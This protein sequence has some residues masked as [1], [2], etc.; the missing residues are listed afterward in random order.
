MK[1]LFEVYQQMQEAAEVCPKCKK[2]PCEC[3]SVEEELKGK[4]IK[5]DKNKNGKLDS[6]D[7]KKLRK[8]D[9]VPFAGPYTK[10]K[11]TV[12][13]K[14]GAKHTGM[15]RARD[16]ARKALANTQKKS[17]FEKYSAEKDKLK[18]KHFGMAEEV[19]QIEELS[20]NTLLSYA[21]KVSADSQKNKMDPTKRNPEKANRSVSGVAKAHNKFFAKEEVELTLEDYSLEELEDYMMSEE[22]EQLDELSKSTLGSYVKKAA[23]DATISRK[24]ASDFEHMSARAKKPSMKASASELEKEYKS[25]SWK[26]RDNIGKAVDR[27]TKEEYKEL[28]EMDHGGGKNPYAGHGLSRDDDDGK[29]EYQAKPISRKTVSKLTLDFLNKNFNTKNKKVTKEEVD[30]Q[31]A[32]HREFASQGKMHPDMA[33]NMVVGRESDYYEPKTGDK[34]SGKVIH[35]NGKE[36]HVKQTADSYDPKKVGTLHKF[37]ISSVSHSSMKEEQMKTYSDLISQ[38]DEYNSKEGVYRHKGKYGTSHDDPGVKSSPFWQAADK[39]EDDEKPKKAAAPAEKRGRGRPAGAKS[40]ARQQGSGSG[41]DYS[42]I[43][44][45]SLNLPNSNR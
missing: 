44:H 5:L 22:F 14:S 43:A 17:G 27:L 37:K 1:S 23:A 13:D 25:K 28:E 26:R 36:V 8:E 42:G 41:S 32:N 19:E 30:L 4:Q 33:K 11:G 20:K 39:D 29:K 15:S 6:D 18:P 10:S 12:T 34:V 35:N 40:G 24:V 38:L 2:S 21:T 45:H 3:D 7:F 31:E 9:S 16:L